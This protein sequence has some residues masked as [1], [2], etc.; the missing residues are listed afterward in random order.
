MTITDTETPQTDSDHDGIPDWWMLKYFGHATG[1]ISDQSCASCDPNSNRC[2]NLCEYG[3]NTDPFAT[4]SSVF[5]PYT[6]NYQTNIVCTTILLDND[7]VVG[8]NTVADVLLIQNGGV[9]SNGFGYVGYET[10]GTYNTVLVTG[11]GSVWSN[12]YDLCVG[13]YGA[14]SSLVISNGGK[15]ASGE[16]ANGFLTYYGNSYVGYTVDS[17]NNSVLV[18][19]PGSSS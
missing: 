7:V 8:S 16:D 14:F 3:R 4:C 11:T 17:S 2:D 10:N 5:Q 1:Q 9:L 12:T 13:W 6:V 18:S 15:V 19:G